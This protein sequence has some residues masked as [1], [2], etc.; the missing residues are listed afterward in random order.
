MISG[1][2][3]EPSV[4]DIRASLS[5]T[6]KNAMDCLSWCT[7]VGDAITRCFYMPKKMNELNIVLHRTKHRL[8]TL[9]KL[10]SRW[11]AMHWGTLSCKLRRAKLLRCYLYPTLHGCTRNMVSVIFVTV[12]TSE[13]ACPHTIAKLLKFIAVLDIEHK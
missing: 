11:L 3:L 6:T 4:H 5:G 2:L 9:Q 7:S 13:W 12:T 1:Y 10:L 8:Q